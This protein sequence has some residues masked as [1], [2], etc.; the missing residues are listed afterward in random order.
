MNIFEERLKSKKLK[1][2]PQR[3]AIYTYLSGT[4]TH[5]NAEKIHSDLKKDFPS[6]SLATI[7]K[8]VASLRD[9]NLV[10]EINVGED[11]HRYDA[12]TNFHSHLICTQ[13]GEVFDYI[14]ENSDVD[15]GIDEENIIT[16][17]NFI[18]KSRQQFFYG[19]C[20]CCNKI[21]M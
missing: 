11:C 8:N 1:I 21:S 16:K 18:V 15:L 6:M 17:H 4:N 5:P 10:Q 19:I 13:C 20:G 3:L 14:N 2:T 12:N 9:A 7:Y